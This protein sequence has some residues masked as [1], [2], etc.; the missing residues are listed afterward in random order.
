MPGIFTCYTRAVS[1]RAAAAL[2]LISLMAAPVLRA[3]CEV[4][5]AASDGAPLATPHCHESAPVTSPFSLSAPD[6][7]GN[8]DVAPAIVTSA[9]SPRTALTTDRVGI[10]SDA[11]VGTSLSRVTLRVLSRARSDTSPPTSPGFSILRI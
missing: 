3:W 7:C 8:H 10:A 11:A 2:V 1:R 5:C 4:T 6:S 9:T